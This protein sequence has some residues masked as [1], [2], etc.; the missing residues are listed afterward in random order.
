MK[1]VTISAKYFEVSFVSLPIGKPARPV[2]NAFCG[3]NFRFLLDMVNVKNSNIGYSATNTLTPKRLDKLNFS[4][5]IS[6]LLLKI[7]SVFVPV[8]LLTIRR[9]KLCFRR[10]SAVVASSILTPSSGMVTSK[11]AIFHTRFSSICFAK[12]NVKRL[13]AM[14]TNKSYSIFSHTNIIPQLPINFAIAEAQKQLRLP[15]EVE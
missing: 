8:I 12:R 13:I 5:P 2:V 11:T 4:L 14:L 1:P 10:L 9:T 15:L 3:R 7:V 6:A